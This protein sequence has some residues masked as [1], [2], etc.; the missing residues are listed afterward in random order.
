MALTALAEGADDDLLPAA[1]EWSWSEAWVQRTYE[2]GLEVWRKP[3]HDGIASS[4]GSW[5]R[6]IDEGRKA[7]VAGLA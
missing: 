2:R 5:A 4:L 3:D 7:Y 1:G 6:A